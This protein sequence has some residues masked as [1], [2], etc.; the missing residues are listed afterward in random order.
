MP[1]KSI[2][3]KPKFLDLTL[4]LVFKSLWYRSNS[5]VRKYLERMVEY[6][7]GH[8]IGEY[9]LGPNE[10][11]ILSYEQIANKVDRNFDNYDK[12]YV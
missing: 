1:N 2:L 4:D 12:K 10:K 5:D 9:T 8:P 11:G 3:E 7:I 6:A